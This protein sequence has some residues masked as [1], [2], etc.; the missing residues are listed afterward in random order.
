MG[1][2][3]TFGPYIEHFRQQEYHFLCLN[4]PESIVSGLCYNATDSEYSAVRDVGVVCN[5]GHKPQSARLAPRHP[6]AWGGPYRG[7]NEKWFVSSAPLRGIES[8]RLCRN[9]KPDRSCIGLLFQYLDQSCQV[10]GQWRWDCKI[11]QVKITD[12][13]PAFIYCQNDHAQWRTLAVEIQASAMNTVS[14]DNKWE[15]YHLQG[16][17]IW[18]FSSCGNYVVFSNMD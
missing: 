13:E 9:A 4:D 10:V 6:I 3:H 7:F 1:R 15:Y 5:L 17:I 12:A 16:L 11:D 14:Y 2:S 8:V 18:W